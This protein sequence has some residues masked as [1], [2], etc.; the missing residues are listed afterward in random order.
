M[1]SESLRPAAS[2]S[3]G[4]VISGS[5]RSLPDEIKAVLQVGQ[6]LPVVVSVNSQGESGILIHGHFVKANLPPECRPGQKLLVIVVE[7]KE[8]LVLKIINDSFLFSEKLLQ[9]LGPQAA[10]EHVLKALLPEGGL[11][12]LK[13]LAVSTQ[14]LQEQVAVFA[15]LKQQT[16][17]ETSAEKPPAHSQVQSQAAASGKEAGTASQVEP[18]PA[19]LSDKGAEHTQAQVAHTVQKLILEELSINPKNAGSPQEIQRV[20]MNLN[21]NDLL[22]YINQAKTALEQLARTVPPAL[23]RQVVDSI[24]EQVSALLNRGPV[25]NFES[26]SA[27]PQPPDNGMLALQLRMASALSQYAL[28]ANNQVLLS[29]MPA[30][31]ALMQG[32]HNPLL[33][34]L[35]ILG[36]FNSPLLSGREQ[37]EQSMWTLL[38]SFF[39]DLTQLKDSKAPSQ[40]INE[41]LRHTLGTLSGFS[42][43]LSTPRPASGAT[44]SALPLLNMLGPLLQGQQILNQLNPLMYS[45]GEPALS[46]IPAFFADRLLRWDMNANPQ[47]VEKDGHPNN[48]GKKRGHQRVQLCL[49]LPALGNVQVD[50]AHTKKEALINLTFDRADVEGFVSARLEHL[51][52]AFAALGYQNLHFSTRHGCTS[53][54]NPDWYIQLTRRSVVA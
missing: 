12:M 46:V 33:I 6:T 19:R 18:A 10:L 37:S 32:N 54:V 49:S 39:T 14:A 4:Q 30:N 45:A 15:Q 26:A 2:S 41:V 38:R 31:I 23:L 51:K 35:Q 1:R 25:L 8:T 34:L 11:D 13:R 50:L 27:P 52:Q 28:A 42:A 16:A 22:R 20:L 40:K 29:A 48:T 44:S 24:R 5:F 9:Q 53:S 21:H 3:P 43:S 36:Q 7:N 47:H 17:R